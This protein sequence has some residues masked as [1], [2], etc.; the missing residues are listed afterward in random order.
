[1]T[2][3]QKWA[4]SEAET[5]RHAY[6][7]A[8]YGTGFANIAQD[9]RWQMEEMRR[10]RRGQA[11]RGALFLVACWAGVALRYWGVLP[12]LWTP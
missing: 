11:I 7:V 6:W 2:N 9:H 8:Q 1:M 3:Q 12:Y 4:Q 10:R 5:A